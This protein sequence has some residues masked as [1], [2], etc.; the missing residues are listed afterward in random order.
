MASQAELERNLKLYPWYSMALESLF[1]APVFILLFASKFS[2][3]EVLLLESVYYIAV[4]IL[5]VPSGY[6]SD[7]MGRRPTLMAAAA[8]LGLSY[9]LFFLGDSFFVFALAKVLMAAGFA[10]KSGT[11]ASFHYD[12]YQSLGR[13]EKF[14]DA[15][16]R[17]SSMNFRGAAGAALLGG[18]AGMS[19]LSIPF[20]LSAIAS[21][22]AMGM[23]STCVEPTHSEDRTKAGFSS[24]LGDTLGRL[25]DRSLRWLMGVA[26]LSIIL[27]HVPYEVY[28][29]YIDL[30]SKD[31]AVSEESSPLISGI[32]AFIVML[33]GSF[34][35]AKSMNIHRKLGM[36]KTFLCS[37]LFQ[38]FIILPAAFVL[39][40]SVVLLM[41][42]RNAP[43]GMYMAPLSSEVNARIPTHLR[44]T[45]L[46]LQSLAGRL[47]FAG[48]L[49]MLSIVVGE[50][51]TSWSS[52]SKISEFSFYLGIT[53][54]M[55][56]LLTARFVDEKP[57]VDGNE[58]G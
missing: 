28:Q 40:P 11:D 45:Y 25:G 16:A 1:W 38:N 10:F 27:V 56:L 3:S 58:S 57:S 7:R 4:V 13:T 47:G 37:I 42:L 29:P 17:V 24:Q 23:M 33:V 26:I 22:V 34:V 39:H 15:E 20:A 50:G 30:V 49:W 44:A 54:W 52:V 48:L 14:G 18:L 41:L 51:Q 9:I 12:T 21:F 19:N 2:I 46:S 32:H 36:R 53:G 55:L 8:L 35:A 6:V 5:E 31:R 43:K